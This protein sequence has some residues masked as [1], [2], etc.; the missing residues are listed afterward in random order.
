MGRQAL[1]FLKWQFKH[2]SISMSQLYAANPDQD[3]ALY[4][5]MLAEYF[6]IKR[7]LLESWCSPDQ[8]LSGGAGRKILEM[9]ASAVPDRDRLV[10]NTAMQINIRATG[11][12]WCIAQDA[13]CGGAGL[14]ENTRCVDCKNS[15]IDEEHFA[16]WQG[17]HDQHREM[18]ALDDLGP[19]VNA[20][21]RRDLALSASVIADF[22]VHID[23]GTAAIQSTE[24]RP[25]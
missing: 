23:S 16:V 18:L 25:K 4:E 7:D 12:G 10:A 21:I 9:R 14:Y 17:I 13:G 3:P 11:H 6:D 20:R 5:D 22:G 19:V 24:G 2:S 1:V 15:V 8:R